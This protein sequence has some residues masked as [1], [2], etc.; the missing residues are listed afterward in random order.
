[1]MQGQRKLEN[2]SELRFPALIQISEQ[3]KNFIKRALDK[4]P[5]RRMSLD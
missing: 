2:L 1:M 5:S 3:A 4:D